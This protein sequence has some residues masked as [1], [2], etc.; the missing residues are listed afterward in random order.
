MNSDGKIESGPGSAEIVDV[1]L[2]TG[3]DPFF[4]GQFELYRHCCDLFQVT[5]IQ[6]IQWQTVSAVL[7]SGMTTTGQEAMCVD[8]LAA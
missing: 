3:S 7:T 5:A 4:R 2:G 8:D 6:S 1:K